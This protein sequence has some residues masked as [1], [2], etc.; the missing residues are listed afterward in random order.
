MHASMRYVLLLLLL[1]L[2]TQAKAGV[3]NT[4]DE[5]LTEIIAK[6]YVNQVVNSYP[7]KYRS[8]LFDVKI[9]LSPESSSDLYTTQNVK[10]RVSVGNAIIIPR[11]YLKSQCLLMLSALAFSGNGQGGK[12]LPDFGSMPDCP[13]IPSRFDCLLSGLEIT[14]NDFEKSAPPMRV[15]NL[16]GYVIVL[17]ES[18]VEYAI[19]HEF[20]HII[21]DRFFPHR[22]TS[23]NYDSE[24]EADLQALTVFAANKA[25]PL[26]DSLLFGARVIEDSVMRRTANGGSHEAPICRASRSNTL[27]KKLGPYLLRITAWGFQGNPSFDASKAISLMRSQAGAMPEISFPDTREVCSNK[28]STEVIAAEGDLKRLDD[29]VSGLPSPLTI[30]DR[31]LGE[32]LRVRMDSSIGRSIRA[33][34]YGGGALLKISLLSRPLGEMSGPDDRKRLLSGLDRISRQIDVTDMSSSDYQQFLLLRAIARFSTAPPGSSFARQAEEL[35]A[36]LDRMIQFGSPSVQFLEVFGMYKL[37][38]G[39]CNGAFAALIESDDLRQFITIRAGYVLDLFNVKPPERPSQMTSIIEV[40]RQL[41][42]KGVKIPP[43]QCKPLQNT[44]GVK[45]AYGW[46]D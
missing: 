25:V 34:L 30:S 44:A 6:R 4:F 35:S 16:S 31:Q 22:R 32:I 23:I 12:T 43:E 27:R 15:K 17:V 3:C 10:D 20:A 1:L 9:I 24:L 36:D 11:R 5:P 42:E 33:S 46:T 39:D 41:R 45:A 18:G 2:A 7:A 21:N 28:L 14:L 29:L 13:N 38:S 40:A 8:T 37:I 26:A 19:A